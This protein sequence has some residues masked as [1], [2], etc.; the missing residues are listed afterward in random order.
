MLGAASKA[1]VSHDFLHGDRQQGDVGTKR[2]AATRRNI[3][4]AHLRNLGEDALRLEGVLQREVCCTLPPR[5]QRPIRVTKRPA[6]GR[7]TFMSR[8]TLWL[9]PIASLVVTRLCRSAGKRCQIRC[10]GR[11]GAEHQ[12]HTHSGVKTLVKALLSSKNE[13]A[14]QSVSTCMHAR[15]LP[16]N[17]P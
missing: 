11:G 1:L 8:C 17:M 9:L 3:G 14:K 10:A 5:I 12:P 2:V 7:I 13:A 15:A 4:Y 6:H 16:P